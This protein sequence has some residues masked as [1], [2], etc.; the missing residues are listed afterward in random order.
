MPNHKL[1]D[2]TAIYETGD[3]AGIWAQAISDR[4]KTTNRA[5]LF[6]DRDG[7]V[8][9]GVDYLH[10]VE[11]TCLVDGAAK[12]IAAANAAGIAVV[13]VTNQA[14]IAYG[15]YGWREF[16]S[17]QQKMLGQLA[18]SGAWIDGVFACPFHAVGK[19]PYNHPDH[20]AR[21]PNPGMILCAEKIMGL[22]LRNS[23]IVGDRASD[24]EAGKRAGLCGGT[25]VLTGH[26]RN[27][28]EREAALA[29]DSDEFRALTAPSIAESLTGINGASPFPIVNA[30]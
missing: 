27:R 19:P 25:H 28:G 3:W 30:V 4:A 12:T 13:I 10:K 7:V 15:Y 22:N 21:K 14:G 5:A 24:L 17:V 6:L 29:L 8:V 16:A 9:K 20:P 2:G 1:P 23:W 18:E 11:D 26:G